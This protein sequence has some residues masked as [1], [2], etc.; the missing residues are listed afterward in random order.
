MTRTAF[1]QV[2]ARFQDGR[3][4]SIAKGLR[5]AGFELVPKPDG[6]D[7]AVTWNL[8]SGAAQYAKAKAKRVFVFEE[9]YTRGLTPVTAFACGLDGH[10]GSGAIR[11]GDRG[12][13]NDVFG[14]RA[15]EQLRPKGKNLLIC[16]SRG[17]G[18][19]GMA[20]PREW[21]EQ[22]I[23]GLRDCNLPV[24]IRPHP[25]D[26]RRAP[27]TES[28]AEDLLNAYLVVTWGSQAATY[29]ALAGIPSYYC[30]PHFCAYPAVMPWEGLDAAKFDQFTLDSPGET[31][32]AAGLES[33][34][35]QQF[36]VPEIESGFPFRWLLG[37][38]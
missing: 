9:G 32:I 17:M 31:D 16:A 12:R 21:P 24:V 25:K 27:R 2:P 36:T 22:F 26:K 8:S 29:A 20:Q 19:P 4:N 30:G 6:A 37:E 38:S 14:L 13:L 18:A 10:N 3:H 33:M 34:A 5:A 1:L 11:I 28:L 35:W 23:T 15:P 7:F